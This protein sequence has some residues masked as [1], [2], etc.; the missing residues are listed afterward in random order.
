MNFKKYICCKTS[1]NKNTVK[2]EI[3]EFLR[4]Y[5]QALK[6]N[7]AAVFA[8]A[9]LSKASGFVDWKGLMREI[10]ANLGL[11]V[12]QETDL[13]AIAQYHIN[14]RLGNRSVINQTIIDHFVK[15]VD[16]TE[17][18][19]ILARLPISSYWTTNYDNLIEEAIKEAGKTPDEKKIS[20]NL[21]TTLSK[22]DAV[23]Y[24]MHGD[25][26]QPNE[27]VIAKEDYETYEKKRG[28]Y[29]MVL[30]S[31]LLSKTFL[32]VGFSFDD[33]NLIYTL[34]RIKNLLGEKASLL[35][36]H[37]FFIKKEDDCNKAKKQELKI[38]D[39]NRYGIKA[40]IV[41]GYEEITIILKK[42][43]EFYKRSNVFI[44]GAA[45][46]F[47]EDNQNEDKHKLF[48]H[49]LTKKILSNQYKIITGKGK[50][51]GDIV[52]DGT[53]HYM[54][55]T[56]YRHLDEFIK[57]RPFPLESVREGIS[58]KEKKEEKKQRNT[59]YRDEMLQEAGVAIFVYGN[60]KDKN[61]TIKNSSGMEEEFNI[62]LEKGIKPIPIGATGYMANELWI[63]VINDFEKYYP[64]NDDNK[65]TMEEIKNLM[66]KIGDDN[67]FK[68]KI[69][70]EDYNTY[71]DNIY[72]CVT[73][74]IKKLNTVNSL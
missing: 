6:D 24:K 17:N 15:N 58:E 57:M 16:L 4:V 37:Y 23:V 51:V 65:T 9:G 12:D 52:I 25:V 3:K 1:K 69:N 18:H 54:F 55:L 35:R 59:K 45:E 36:T 5:G 40:L 66:Q 20:D 46:C 38:K 48:V 27:A 19:R 11:D 7:N 64:S 32:F 29:S 14:E 67:K 43:N 49:N 53:L 63:K 56:D 42:L 72:D 8:G 39:L 70:Q 30:Q 41:D 60:K 34:A 73:E 68:E 33:P 2:P 28:A 22:R 61:G 62:A 26:V 74:I 47:E 10:A 44:S 50:K 71:F 31:E 13:I 21:L